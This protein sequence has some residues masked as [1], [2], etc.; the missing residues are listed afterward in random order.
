[1]IGDSGRVTIKRAG[2]YCHLIKGALVTIWLDSDHDTLERELF[3][4]VVN[5]YFQ[6][7]DWKTSPFISSDNSTILGNGV[8]INQRIGK[9]SKECSQT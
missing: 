3:E 7:D 5:I 9:Y 1:M 4:E 6:V 8:N 2:L